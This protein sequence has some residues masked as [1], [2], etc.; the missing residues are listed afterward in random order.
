VTNGVAC[1]TA[2]MAAAALGIR[3]LTQIDETQ[4]AA[5]QRA[6][7]L[8]AM[9]NALQPG[10]FALSGWDLVGALT[11]PADSVAGLMADGDTRW[12][13]RGAYDLMGVDS[14]ATHSQAGLPRAR[15]LYGSLPEQLRDPGSFANQLRHLLD[16]RRCN[17]IYESRQIAVP[18]VR[19]PSLLVMVHELPDRLGLEI[20]ALNF[21]TQPVEEVITMPAAANLAVREALRDVDEGA[22][23]EHGRFL[24]QLQGHEG[25]AYLVAGR[26]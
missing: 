20:T 11:L 21:A 22:F 7:L 24:I 2:S 3:D 10:V 19:S 18:D 13:N 9:Y 26:S 25:K 14:A 1:T 6:H 8:L 15:A 16:V 12:V 17:R 23:D 4:A 5:I